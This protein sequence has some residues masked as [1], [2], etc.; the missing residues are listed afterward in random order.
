MKG[1]LPCNARG[2]FEQ[3]LGCKTRTYNKDTELG[4]LGENQTD[5]KRENG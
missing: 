2:G 4:L 3:D 1:C 5:M